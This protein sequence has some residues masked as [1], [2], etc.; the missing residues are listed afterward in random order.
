MADTG[1]TQ[2]P[3]RRHHPPPGLRLQRRGLFNVSWFL[4]LMVA[5]VGL[6]ICPLP[7]EKK[8]RRCRQECGMSLP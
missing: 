3:F 7:Q 6:M 5:V 2:Q 8:I 4:G 1:E